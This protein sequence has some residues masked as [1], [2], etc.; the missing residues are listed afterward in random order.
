MNRF[1][2][3]VCVAGLLALGAASAFGADAGWYVGA[4]LGP[5]STNISNTSIANE[6]AIQSPSNSIQGINKDDKSMTYRM[7]VGYN[8]TSFL[9]LEASLFQLGQFGFNANTNYAGTLSPSGS[10]SGNLEVW[11]G[12]FDIVGIIPIQQWRLLG[13]VGVL[14]GQTKV[15]LGG[16][17]AVVI[18]NPSQSS[19]FSETKV[20]YDFGAGVGY[21]FDSGVA[22]RAEWIY[23][24]TADGMGGD[25]KTNT[26]Q[27]SVLYRF[28]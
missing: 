10:F 27:A 8:V 16:T 6:L 19:S 20:G 2:Q 11:G 4:G 15:S 14:Y 12:N 17:G 24:K 3:R 25:L 1:A 13:R 5:S 18:P 26:L 28:Q 22:F 9:A 21:E 23:Y 7:F